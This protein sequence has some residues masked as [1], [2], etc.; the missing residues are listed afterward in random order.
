MGR[1]AACQCNW[2]GTTAPVKA[3]LETSELILRGEIRKRVPFA[4]MTHVEAH[5]GRLS[6]RSAGEQV[7]L[8]LGE[9]QAA[10]WAA[11]IKAGPVPLARKLGITRE[12]I[13]R[14]LGDTSDESLST[15]F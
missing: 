10:K 11:A 9:A 2:A 6:F 13:V 8:V 4:A 3:L 15:A 12:S 5:S 1:E 7:E 14:T